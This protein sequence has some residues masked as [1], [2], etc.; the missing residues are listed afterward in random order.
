MPRYQIDLPCLADPRVKDMELIFIGWMIREFNLLY[1]FFQHLLSLAIS[2]SSA[3]SKC[4]ISVPVKR[5]R[6][7]Q[8]FFFFSKAFISFFCL[9]Y[10][11]RLI[12]LEKLWLPGKHIST[13][14]CRNQLLYEV[15]NRVQKGFTDLLPPTNTAGNTRIFLQNQAA[16]SISKF[17]GSY[18]LATTSYRD[19]W[20]V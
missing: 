13:L 3:L 6:V 18:I 2:L 1:Q 11:N 12:Q 19:Y 9:I 15:Q 7:F 17:I 5:F 4:Y 14:Q 8:L 10:A 16:A 20:G